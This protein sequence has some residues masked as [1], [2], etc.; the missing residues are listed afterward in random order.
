MRLRHEMFEQLVSSLLGMT[1][2]TLNMISPRE[3]PHI[4]A[5]TVP[6]HTVAGAF[7]SGTVISSVHQTPRGSYNGRSR[8]AVTNASRIF[9]AATRSDPSM[10]LSTTS[11]RMHPALAMSIHLTTG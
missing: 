6:M 8:P 1:M 2:T 11:N 10:K 9:L 5:F 4:T 3:G 7:P